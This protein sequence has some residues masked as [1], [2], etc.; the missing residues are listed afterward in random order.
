MIFRSKR[1]YKQRREP[2][3]TNCPFCQKKAVLDYKEVELLARYLSDRGKI[4]GRSKTGLCQ[5]HQNRL[6]QTIKRARHLALLPF[7]SKP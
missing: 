6:T 7:V 4:M 1:T 3:V 5:K 2:V